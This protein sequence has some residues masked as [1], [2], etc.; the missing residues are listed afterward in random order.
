[1][2]GSLRMMSRMHAR[3]A[4]WPTLA[5]T[6]FAALHVAAWYLLVFG[7]PAD[8][9]SMP[10]SLAGAAS[11]LCGLGLAS[12]IGFLLYRTKAATARLA[13][14]EQRFRD[15]AEAAGDWFWETSPDQRFTFMSRSAAGGGKGSAN[16]FIGRS[17]LALISPENGPEVSEQ[18]R[19]DLQQQ[20]AFRDFVY[21]RQS[22]PEEGERWICSSGK[23]FYDADGSFLGHR[24]VASDITDTRA[25]REEMARA[26]SRLLHTIELIP[27]GLA[28]YGPDDKLVLCNDRYREMYPV[29]ADMIQPGMAFEELVRAAAARNAYAVP[30]EQLE[31]FL[32]E[33]LAAHRRG[34]GVSEHRLHDGRWLQ[35]NVRRTE[36]GSRIGVWTDVSEIKRREEALRQSEQRFLSMTANIPGMVFQASFGQGADFR[37]T[38]IS[39]GVR[40]LFGVEPEAA[41]ADIAVLRRRI[42]PE[43]AQSVGAAMMQA[44]VQFSRFDAEFRIFDRSGTL[45]WLRCMASPQRLND[46]DVRWDGVVEDVTDRKRYEFALRES[47]ERYALAM[48][49][50][51]EGLWYWDIVTGDVAMSPRLADLVGMAVP[52]PAEAQRL[53]AERVHPEDRERRRAAYRD[54]MSGRTPVFACEYRIQDGSGGWRWLFDRGLAQRDGFGRA[55]RMAGSASDVTARKAYEHELRAAKEAAEM[56][57]RTKT[58]LLAN[59]SH[60][61]RTPLNAIIGFSQIIRDELMG[62]VGTPKYQEYATDINASGAHLLAV[63]ND[64]L[65][66][67]KIEAGKAELAEEEIDVGQAA[68][69]ALRLVKQ[70]AEEATLAIECCLP[71]NLP[72]LRADA[73]KLKQILINLLSNSV[74]FTPAGGAITLSADLAPC[75]GMVIRVRDTGIGIAPEDIAKA[76]APFGQVDSRLNRRYEGTGLGLTLVQSLIR[77]HGG[78]VDLESQLGAGTTVA[79]LFP[80]ERVLH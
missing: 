55:F 5:F 20:R 14:S 62:P 67:A 3:W 56:A 26:T 27:E 80:P 47:E 60:E 7:T 76:L 43:D 8:Q 12:G 65:D 28:L 18:H 34:D 15:F 13:V 69:A 73:R 77:L 57:N 24:G 78:S 49:G 1:M 9:S 6:A 75:G 17:P 53:F 66:M 19:L 31:A 37:F 68:E 59:V 48:Q 29:V 25:M 22:N 41:L 33:R 51:N 36:D 61:L 35:V 10:R 71:G 45:K 38:F 79:V 42:H 11:L 16:P 21:R 40:E 52:D 46:G 50:A 32:Q 2:G 58:E 64:I 63:I 72:R 70:R 74:K 30:P 4:M 39:E 54:H 44:T 23:P